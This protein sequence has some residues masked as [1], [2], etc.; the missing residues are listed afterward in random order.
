[1][2]YWK[3]LST[4][5]KAIV[6][7]VAFIIVYGIISKA[8]NM[9]PWPNEKVIQADANKTVAEAVAETATSAIETVVEGDRERESLR[10]AAVEVQNEI[11]KTPTN[12]PPAVT[13]RAV[14]NA[15]CK[16]PEYAADP[17]CIQKA[18]VAAA[19]AEGKSK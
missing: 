14:A 13:R 5:V 3:G 1:M 15:V 18:I 16:L 4:L 12:A 6:I 19:A 11:D 9:W 17:Q 7:L 10:E 8:L 2:E